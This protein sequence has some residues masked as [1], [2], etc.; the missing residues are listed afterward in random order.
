MAAVVRHF[1]ADNKWFTTPPDRWPPL[2]SQALDELHLFLPG[3]RQSQEE[4]LQAVRDTPSSPR[5]DLGAAVCRYRGGSMPPFFPL[6][7]ACKENR[8]RSLERAACPPREVG[9]P[10]PTTERASGRK[11]GC[12]FPPLFCA[13]TQSIA[14]KPITNP[15]AVHTQ[16]KFF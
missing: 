7:A 3:R 9:D 1:P 12:H 5:R 15:S 2:L 16:T 11:S 6:S 4:E 13:K 8:K 14:A 10:P